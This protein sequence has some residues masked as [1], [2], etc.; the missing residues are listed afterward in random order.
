MVFGV[1]ECGAGVVE[2]WCCGEVQWSGEENV[3]G[4]VWWCVA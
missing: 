1:I 3:S 2:V 4:G